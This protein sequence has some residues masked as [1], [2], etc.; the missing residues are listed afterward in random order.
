[1]SANTIPFSTVLSELNVKGVVKRQY[2]GIVQHVRTVRLPEIAKSA[3]AK[4]G[5][6]EGLF[7]YYATVLF[8]EIGSSVVS[9]H[10]VELDDFGSL[11]LTASGT[12]DSANAHWDPSANRIGISISAKGRL[13][14]AAAGLAGR[15][16]TEGN[17]V[18]LKRVVDGTSRIE[19]VIT[20]AANVK[21][22]LSG[23]SMLVT[24]GAADEGVWLE[25]ANGEVV[26]TATVDASTMTT[27][28]CT[29]TTLPVED[30][31][32][33]LVVAARGGLSMEYG[34]SIAHRNVKVQTAN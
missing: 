15:N 23:D 26:A 21:V 31:S 30:G 14:D 3:A 32:Y 9:G 4:L 16:V 25:N 19:N 22:Y 5:V 6:P 11:Y 12:F 20:N 24:A 18:I 33:R 13:K 17:H 29:F 34:V 10:R 7:T 1:M 27:V 2:R 8:D 28:D